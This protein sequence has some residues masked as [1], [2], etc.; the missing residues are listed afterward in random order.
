MKKTDLFLLFVLLAGLAYVLY[1]RKKKADPSASDDLIAKEA[2][3]EIVQESGDEFALRP[4]ST[5]DNVKRLQIYLMRNFGMIDGFQVNGVY[6]TATTEM[7]SRYLYRQRISRGYFEKT[8]MDL[9][10][11]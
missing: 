6:D 5:G 3:I 4:G 10:K 9:I 8:G 7:V 2:P 1:L 11:L